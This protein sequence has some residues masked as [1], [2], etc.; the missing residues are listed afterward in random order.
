[1][2]LPMLFAVAVRGHHFAF[3]MCEGF[4]CRSVGRENKGGC[5]HHSLRRDRVGGRRAAQVAVAERL[6]QRH[7]AR[8]EVGHPDGE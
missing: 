2:M 8:R 6:E 5:R 1:M 3:H 4:F 7:H